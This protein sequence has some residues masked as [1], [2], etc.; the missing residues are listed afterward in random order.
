MTTLR[1]GTPEE[2]GMLPDRVDR[3]KALPRAGSRTA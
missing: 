1:A 3:V 2:A